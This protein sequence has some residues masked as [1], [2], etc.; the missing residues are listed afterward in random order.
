MLSMS[1]SHVHSFAK[2]YSNN[3]C[4]VQELKRDEQLELP[5]ELDYHTVGELST[6]DREKLSK[7][8]PPTLAHAQR[9]AGVTPAALVALFRHLK[10][11]KGAQAGTA[12]GA[13]AA[14]A[15]NQRKGGYAGLKGP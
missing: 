1:G 15:A 9:I 10:K 12:V 11:R 2:A 13:A 14:A 5:P 4:Q 7:E 6:E 8:R 3:A